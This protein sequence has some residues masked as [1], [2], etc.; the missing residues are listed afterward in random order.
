MLTPILC[1][2]FGPSD[3]EPYFSDKTALSP[4]RFP[5]SR[6]YVK[7]LKNW[8]WFSSLFH[9]ARSGL[10]EYHDGVIALFSDNHLAHTLRQVCQTNTK[11][12]LHEECIQHRHLLY[13]KA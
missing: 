9:V 3:T 5:R 1:V 10:R 4:I 12:L 8:L 2:S 13:R 11:S 6:F 7:S